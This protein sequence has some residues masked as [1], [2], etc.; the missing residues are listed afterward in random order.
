MKYKF[1]TILCLLG[2]W[3]GLSLYINK[4]VILPLPYDVLLKMFTLASSSDFYIAIIMTLLRIM[5]SFIIALVLGTLI[6]IIAGLYKPLDEL[7][8]PLISLLQTI[9]QI[10]YILILLV[11]LQSTTALIVII[12]LMIFPVFYHNSKYGIQQIK[13]DYQDILKIYYQPFS[14]NFIHVYLPLMKQYIISAIDTCLPLSIKVGVMSEIFVSSS[15]GIGRQL[16]LARMQI[17][18]TSIFAWT[19]WM[20]IIIMVINYITHYAMKHYISS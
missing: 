18:M 14:Y 20:V 5:L 2:I 13:H 15:Y 10:T 4:E 12:L 9:P 7:L 1:I 16:Y 11:W 6:G 8:K 17:D 3:Q 19:I